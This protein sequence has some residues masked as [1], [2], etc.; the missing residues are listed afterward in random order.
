MKRFLTLALVAALFLFS[1]AHVYAQD[2]GP[3]PPPDDTVTTDEINDIA[4]DLYCPVCENI[5]LDVCE[6]QACAD[7]RAEIRLMLEDGRSE[8]EIQAYFVERY[9][10]RVLAN[11][12]RAGIDLFIYAAPPLAIIGGLGA[13]VVTLRRMSPSTLEET[14]APEAALRY[15]GLDPDYVERVND[16]LREF[17]A[18]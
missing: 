6:T 8:E 5:P 3:Q 2:E 15:E 1:A 14:I 9:G 7:W 18:G 17:A 12:E 11:P 10:K 13:L 4:S 16:E